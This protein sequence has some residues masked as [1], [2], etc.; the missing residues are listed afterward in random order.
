MNYPIHQN[1]KAIA[2]AFVCFLIVVFF[3]FSASHSYPVPGGD[4][5]FFLVPALQFANRGVLTNPL[6]IDKQAIAT[7]DPS[8]EERFIF[9]PP[10]F[11]LVLSRGMHGATPA[12]IFMSIAILNSL[13]I[14]ITT[15]MWCKIAMKRWRNTILAIVGL[16]ALASG[17]VGDSG[18]PEILG[19]F[20]VALGGVVALY[21]TEKYKPILYGVLLGLLFATHFIGGAIGLL[22]VGTFYAAQYDIRNFMRRYCVVFGVAVITFCFIIAIGPFGIIETASGTVRNALMVGAGHTA[23]LSSVFTLE[24]FLQYYVLSPTTPF[25]IFVLILLCSASIFF[26]KKN[27]NRIVLKRIF[28]LCVGG[29]AIAVAGMLYSIGHIFYLIIFTPILFLAFIQYAINSQNLLSTFFVASV[30]VL[31]ATGIVRTGLLLPAF[32]NEGKTFANVRESFRVIA[33][34]HPESDLKIAVTGSFWA[35]SEKYKNMYVYNTW[36]EKVMDGTGFVFFQQR[37]SGMLVPPAITGCSL[38]LDEFSSSS[39]TLFGIKLGNSASGYGYA[40][41]DCIENRRA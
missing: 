40:V 14:F 30:F 10:L 31:V 35:L 20:I 15:L 41:Y 1:L 28:I 26:Y 39:P 32:L 23:Q 3:I 12:D 19:S 17:L 36:P 13:T 27:I 22:V 5:G 21:A 4:S 29:I 18:R 16:L 37:Y 24:T 6:F 7:L 11:P 8:G 34:T 33:K 9:Y 38:I 2:L 25:Y